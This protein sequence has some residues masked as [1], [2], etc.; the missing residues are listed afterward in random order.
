[1]TLAHLLR[2]DPERNMARFYQVDVAP[3]LFDEV[4]VMRSWG[5]IGTRGRTVVETWATGEG[6]D[7]AKSK[8]IR[9][10]L[11]RGYVDAS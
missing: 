9:A 3:T 1:M 5:R 10:K 8:T 11:K 6:A 4:S 7:A 2:R